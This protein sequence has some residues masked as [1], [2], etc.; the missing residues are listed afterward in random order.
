MSIE[1]DYQEI[2]KRID[3]MSREC[4]TFSNPIRTLIA[5]LILAKQEINW[6]QLKELVEKITGNSI[7]PNTL[8]FHIGRLVEM[9]YIEKVGTK[10]Q[11]VYRIKKDN[12]PKIIDDIDPFVAEIL[13][14]RFKND[15]AG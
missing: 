3:K 6:T 1:Q 15:S 4:E 12:L 13:Q 14:R 11:P 7:N 8:S 10:E 5:S 9:E 2:T